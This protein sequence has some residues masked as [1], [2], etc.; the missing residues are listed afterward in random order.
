[1]YESSQ[2]YN[3]S[4]SKCSNFPKVIFITEIILVF[5]W[6]H[7]SNT[8]MAKLKS[9]HIYLLLHVSKNGESKIKKSRLII[10]I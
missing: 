9:K 1:M 10:K 5:H 2:I 6:E 8:I 3:T 7:I 4:Y